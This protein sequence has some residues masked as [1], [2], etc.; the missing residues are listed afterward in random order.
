MVAL[1]GPMVGV[2]AVAVGAVV[3]MAPRIAAMATLVTPYSPGV[4]AADL[5]GDLVVN[6]HPLDGLGLHR[7]ALDGGSTA[8]GV[9]MQANLAHSTSAS[10]GP[11]GGTVGSGALDYLVWRAMGSSMSDVDAAGLNL[12]A[13]ALTGAQ[14]DGGG[15]VWSGRDL[16]VAVI[17]VGPRDDIEAAAHRLLGEATRRRGPWHLAAAPRGDGTVTVRLTGAGGPIA[18][19]TV[20]FS[21]GAPAWTAEAV[22]DDDGEAAVEPPLDTAGDTNVTVVRARVSGP[23]RAVEYAAAGA[24]RIALSGSPELLEVDVDRPLVPP[25]TS[26]LTTAIPT[27]TAST[28]NPAT[29]TNPASTIPPTS[30]APTSVPASAT[31]TTTITVTPA[32]ASNTAP[33]TTTAATTLPAAT[34]VP[35]DTAPPDTA[36]P[37]TAPPDTA[38]PEAVAPTGPPMPA[39]GSGSRGV[40]RLGSALFAVGGVATYVAA[41]SRRS[42]PGR[43]RPPDRQSSAH[44][45]DVKE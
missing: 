12:A 36:A 37:D 17:G 34:T 23:G 15:I 20:T 9:C 27:T 40:V 1:V 21:V 8:F 14:R 42:R 7:M 45:G 3:G 13:W 11:A 5:G 2:F 4:V 25:T 41:G 28:T 38:A 19:E 35:S 6:S 43:L 16:S 31:A 18:G 30:T 44:S 26:P 39:T 29:T 10:Y 22:T 33:A 32:T 24:Q